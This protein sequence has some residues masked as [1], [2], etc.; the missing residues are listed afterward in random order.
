MILLIFNNRG[1]ME[2]R[3]REVAI[4]LKIEPAPFL[5]PIN[6]LSLD[7]MGYLYGYGNLGV[8]LRLAGFYDNCGFIMT[9]N[10]FSRKRKKKVV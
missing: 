2:E 1:I 3:Q 4:G 7:I 6:M 5:Y 10:I 8:A 9:G